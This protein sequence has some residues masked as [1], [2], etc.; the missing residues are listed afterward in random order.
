[1]KIMKSKLTIIALL[2]FM[3][4]SA[5]L[6]VSMYGD[7]TIN[8][9]GGKFNSKTEHPPVLAIGARVQYADSNTNLVSVMYEYT[10]LAS[11]YNGLYLGF[12]K[13]YDLKE[14][15]NIHRGFFK[16]LTMSAFVD[17]GL[18]QRELNSKFE[19]DNRDD[20]IS[21]T[22]GLNAITSYEVWKGVYIDLHYIARLRT[23]IA[24][25]IIGGNGYLGLRGEPE[26]I[27]R[28][29]KKIFN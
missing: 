3:T 21:I 1:M 11:K 18:I 5:Q 9:V 8:T 4:T 26:A 23:D 25:K 17:V 6:S 7:P 15:W 10:N 12:G 22:T 20:P 29:I 28:Y 2:A 19:N 16:H 14:D 24:G 13:S 27:A